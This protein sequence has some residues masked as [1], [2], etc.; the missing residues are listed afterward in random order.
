MPHRFVAFALLICGAL[1]SQAQQALTDRLRPSSEKPASKS[2]GES[3]WLDLRQNSPTHSK[4]QSAPNW[5]EAVSMVPGQE[6]DG[7]AKTLFRIR[8]AR[9]SNDYSV[10]FFRLFF[11][12]KP[13]AQPELVAWDESGSQ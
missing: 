9:P 12:D 7:T 1:S 5:I 10:L 11:D 4:A 8:I 2:A 13:D 3:A 6:A